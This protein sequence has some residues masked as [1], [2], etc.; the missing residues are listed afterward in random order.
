MHQRGLQSDGRGTGVPGGDVHAISSPRALRSPRIAVVPDSET[1]GLAEPDVGSGLGLTSRG[2]HVRPSPYGAVNS[3][4][5]QK[6]AR[7]QPLINHFPA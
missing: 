1:I 6:S 4:A 5:I 3:H 7:Y 2:R